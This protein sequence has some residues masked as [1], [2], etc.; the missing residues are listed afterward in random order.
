MLKIETDQKSLG[1]SL[2]APLYELVIEHVLRAALPFSLLEPALDDPDLLQ[3]QQELF[4]DN[5]PFF[6]SNAQGPGSCVSFFLLWK[7][8]PHAFTFALEILSKWLCPGRRLTV[9]SLFASDLHL[10]QLSDTT[11]SLCEIVILPS[12]LTEYEEIQRNIPLIESELRLGVQSKYL[13]WRILEV[14][15]LN[16]DEKS[17]IILEQVNY[18]IKRQPT[19]FD[20]DLITEMQHMLVMFQDEFINSHDSRYLSRLVSTQYIYRREIRNAVNSDP[21]TRHL[22]LKLFKAK[23]QGEESHRNIL[24]ILLAVNFI[25][26]NEVFEEK[27]ILK[28]VRN[29]ISTV[30]SVEGSFI[31]HRR[32]SEKVCTI[33]L[34][35]E[36]E[37][38]AAFSPQEVSLLR[39]ELPYDLRDRIEHLMH[40]VFM[41]RNEEDIMRNILSLS[42]QIKYVRD[43]PQVFISFEEQTRDSLL[44]SLIMVQVCMPGAPTLQELVQYVDTPLE[45]IHD[46][47]KTV[48]MLRKKYAKQATVC[49]VKLKKHNF[50]RDDGSIDLNKAR[51]YVVDELVKIIGDFRDF[52][53][54]MI[55]KQNEQLCLL[56]QNLEGNAKFNDLLLENFFY[57]LTPVTMR[58]VLEVGILSK[59][60]HLLLEAMDEHL[61]DTGTPILKLVEESDDL[62]VVASGESAKINEALFN[63]TTDLRLDP[64]KLVHSY[65]QVY[66]APYLCFVYRTAERELRREFLTYLETT[67]KLEC[68]LL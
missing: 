45:Y 31:S 43:V 63:L 51:Q 5:L 46:R 55:S 6:A 53:G 14:K 8:R 54:G 42:S 67:L 62:L 32:G 39:N 57:A 47:C 28:A 48:G 41:P 33:Y 61:F 29:Y 3:D 13:A 2:T 59:L 44:F 64:E 49:R 38:G 40:P 21:G 24:G 17:V 26:D 11:L 34:E 36:K 22:L 12:S 19:H 66:N 4:E 9:T 23:L 16:S 25:G 56:R 27:H 30:V 18:L 1:S 58:T 10:P 50:L 52:N 15:G 20:I 68:V 65:V 60:F 35:I 7:S 37:D